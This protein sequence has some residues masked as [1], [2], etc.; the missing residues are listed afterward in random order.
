[1][2]GNQYRRAIAPIAIVILIVIAGASSGCLWAPD[3]AR[4]RRDIHALRDL[5][6]AVEVLGRVI[7]DAN[8]Q[9]LLPR[10]SD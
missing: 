8:A 4:V 10:L 2:Y 5:D 9:G 6:V 1:M 3:L 7:I